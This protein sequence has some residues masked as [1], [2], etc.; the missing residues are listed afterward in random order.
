MSFVIISASDVLYGPTALSTEDSALHEQ[1]S[2]NTSNSLTLSRRR[3]GRAQT[4]EARQ[5]EKNEK[6]MRKYEAKLAEC[7]ERNNE[8]KAD[9][10]REK[11][12]YMMQR[13]KDR[14]AVNEDTKLNFD[15]NGKVL[16]FKV[17]D[18][19]VRVLNKMAAMGYSI[20]PSAGGSSNGGH[21]HGHG[22]FVWTL[23][24]P[25]YQPQPIYPILNLA[26]TD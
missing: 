19:P 26:S 4:R 3:R 14:V 17:D 13:E 5:S 25:N 1:L 9:K 11:I 22:N 18:A 8:E 15:P 23:F 24:R 10:I 16:V 2:G 21:G 7:K 6:I 12:E 20:L